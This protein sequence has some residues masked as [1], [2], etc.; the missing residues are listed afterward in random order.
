MAG[1]SDLST[2]WNRQLMNCICEVV[3]N[4]LQLKYKSG[5]RCAYYVYPTAIQV[6]RP[7][8][9]AACYIGMT[10]E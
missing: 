9:L 2:P 7:I 5:W 6:V 8:D 4:Y 10:T 3:S 1:S